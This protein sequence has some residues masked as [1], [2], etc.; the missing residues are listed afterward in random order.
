MGRPTIVEVNFVQSIDGK[1]FKQHIDWM[2]E[3]D[4]NVNQ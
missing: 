1:V 2:I 3:S 4:L